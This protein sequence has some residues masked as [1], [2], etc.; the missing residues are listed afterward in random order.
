MSK[1]F[2]F[3]TLQTAVSKPVLI[4]SENDR[5]TTSIYLEDRTKL[6]ETIL[7]AIKTMLAKENISLSEISALGF[8][9]GPGS[10]TGMRIGGSVIQT[11]SYSLK[12]PMIGFSSLESFVPEKDGIFTAALDARSGG[13]YWIAGNR[14]GSNVTYEGSSQKNAIQDWFPKGTVV[15]PDSQILLKRRPDLE[16]VLV[17]TEI[18]I[19]HIAHLIYQKHQKDNFKKKLELFYLSNPSK[20]TESS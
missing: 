6:T 11:I 16:T 18:D 2:T 4:L 5:G 3:L 9:E 10:F 19:S 1:K 20:Q 8:C 13:V 17:H 15:S 7:P 14:K 12:I